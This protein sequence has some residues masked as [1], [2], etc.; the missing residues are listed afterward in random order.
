MVKL[1][2]FHSSEINFNLI[3]SV[4]INA[5]KAANLWRSCL[6]LNV[7]KVVLD[8]NIKNEVCWQIHTKRENIQRIPNMTQTTKQTTISS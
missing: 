1:S 8:G 5:S 4:L 6:I 3:L 2:N 7:L